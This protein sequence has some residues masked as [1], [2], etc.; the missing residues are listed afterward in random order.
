MKA[1]VFNKMFLWIFFICSFQ[2][3]T[4]QVGIG[5]SNPRKALEVAGD[6]QVSQTMDVMYFNDLTDSGT[7]SFLLQE[8]N[9]NIKSI[10]VSNPSG[11]SLGYIQEY[12]IVNPNSDWVKDFDT[13]IDANDFVLVVISA[14]YNSDLQIQNGNNRTDNFT[15]PYTASFVSGGTWHMISDY[16]MAANSNNG[17]EGIW[18][19]TTLI[20]SNDLNKQFGII[21]IPMADGTTGS[22]SSPIID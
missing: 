8:S 22:A 16:P 19:I 9:N 10:D 12:I 17:D 15:I 1:P 11:A 4:A 7:S 21:N 5:T 18:I 6:M 20:F 14:V 13:G 3:L 2:F